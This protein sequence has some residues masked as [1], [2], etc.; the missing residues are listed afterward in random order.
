M[1]L[2]LWGGLL[3]SLCWGTYVVVNKVVTS[4]R[5]YGLPSSTSALLMGIG[6][7]ATLACYFMFTG[8]TLRGC[9]AKVALVAILPG[10]IWA[11]GMIVVLYA[12]GKGAP[13]S[14]LVLVYNTNT[15]VAVLVGA[16]VLREVPRGAELIRVIVGAAFVTAGILIASWE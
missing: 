12:L 15:F 16:L 13:V 14:K 2:W 8:G 4:P 9:P 5:Y 6:A 3:A 10:A 7:T 11:L 1:R